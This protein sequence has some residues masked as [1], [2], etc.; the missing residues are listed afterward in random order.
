[1]ALRS[2]AICFALFWAVRLSGGYGNAYQYSSVASFEFWSFA[3][4][5]PDL[6]F[7]TWSLAIVFATLAAVRHFFAD[8]VP[9]ALQ[10]FVT[11]GRVPFFFYVVHFYVLGPLAGPIGRKLDLS[12]TFLVWIGLLALMLWPCAWY[13]RKKLE[14]PNWV[15]RYL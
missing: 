9:R 3:K 1:M 13:Y 4:Y 5:P 14:R 2:A 6:P 10:P 12:G 7:I 8:G 15:T 11:F